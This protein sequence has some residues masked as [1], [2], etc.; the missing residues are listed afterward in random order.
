M[1][2]TT[3]TKSNEPNKQI[4]QDEDIKI[5]ELLE[6]YKQTIASLNESKNY[7]TGLVLSE[8]IFSSLLEITNNPKYVRIKNK[9][10]KA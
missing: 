6:D 3:I 8:K 4:N 7:Q 1:T 5:E 10:N 2:T 9:F